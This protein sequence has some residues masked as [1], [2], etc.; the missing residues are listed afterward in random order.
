MKK[1]FIV[2]LSC[3]F[4][5]SASALSNKVSPLVHKSAPSSGNRSEGKEILGYFSLGMEQYGSFIQAVE[6]FNKD[7]CTN[8]TKSDLSEG[9][10]FKI[11]NIPFVFYNG[12]PLF[13]TICCNNIMENQ[14]EDAAQ[15]KDEVISSAPAVNFLNDSL[16]SF[17][18][19]SV[20]TKTLNY[21][22]EYGL[23]IDRLKADEPYRALRQTVDSIVVSLTKKYG[24]PSKTF[25]Q[26]LYKPCFTPL[27]SE[28]GVVE[29]L[30]EWTCG[31][32]TICTG[33]RVEGPDGT[34]RAF[35]SFADN[36]KM[37]LSY[38]K[39][40]FAK[41]EDASDKSVQW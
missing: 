12:Y 11:D 14:L 4:A 28:S 40:A 20:T 31:A 25:S 37:R 22:G 8:Y 39:K 13:S 26:R 10:C 6:Q 9:R 38:L 15:Y 24:K 21:E 5:S 32:L 19:V 3:L 29:P 35:V 41:A 36:R 16:V 17:F 18:I 30:Y 27:F 34:S 23:S 2:F 7:K 33:I 1:L